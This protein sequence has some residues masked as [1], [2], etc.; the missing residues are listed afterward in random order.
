[1]RSPP[2]HRTPAPCSTL[3]FANFF[4]LKLVILLTFP[5]SLRMRYCLGGFMGVRNDAVDDVVGLSVAFMKC[6]IP[7]M[8]SSMPL[9]PCFLDVSTSKYA[10]PHC[11]AISLAL[12]LWT[13]ISASAFSLNADGEKSSSASISG[14]DA[15]SITAIWSIRGC[16]QC[17]TLQEDV[18][19]GM[20]SKDA[21]DLVVVPDLH[22]GSL[23]K[24]LARSCLHPFHTHSS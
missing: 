4:Q 12:S 11:C 5:N 10:Q 8:A 14:G 23:S 13:F 7:V 9:S 22:H 6:P 17:W 3:G 1:M 24:R 18:A 21:T 20:G 2:P 19:K 16:C 15:V